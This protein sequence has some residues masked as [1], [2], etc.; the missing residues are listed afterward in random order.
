MTT[1]AALDFVSNPTYSIKIRATDS[2]G[3]KQDETL[4]VFPLNSAPVIST[5]PSS[6]DV[7]ETQVTSL[8]LESVVATDADDDTLT[9]TLS[10]SPTG[11]FSVDNS[12]ELLDSATASSSSLT[13]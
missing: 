6:V 5:A 10:A 12:G 1:N 7:L 8:L 3:Q 9:Y 11:P 4:T 13:V 2:T